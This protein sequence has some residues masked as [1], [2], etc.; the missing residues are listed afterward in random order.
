MIVFAAVAVARRPVRADHGL[1]IVV[2]IHLGQMQDVPRH[3]RKHQ[4]VIHRRV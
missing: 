3:H 2:G 4:E 1:G